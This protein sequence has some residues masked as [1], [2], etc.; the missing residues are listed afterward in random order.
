MWI[1]YDWN[2]I[3][4]L[5]HFFVPIIKT[6][7]CPLLIILIECTK[8]LWTVTWSQRKN[9]IFKKGCTFSIK[10]NNTS[11]WL[12]ACDKVTAWDACCLETAS[13]QSADDLSHV[14]LHQGCVHSE[15]TCLVWAKRHR[16]DTDWPIS[17]EQP[18]GMTEGRVKHHATAKLNLDRK[19]MRWNRNHWSERKTDLRASPGSLP[20][21]IMHAETTRVHAVF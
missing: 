2:V 12:T 15:K 19:I 6:V 1:N 21:Y 11:C 8:K 17:S 14:P 16:G 7:N 5:Y 13:S 3:S 18:Q 10:K 9:D 20:S 4:R